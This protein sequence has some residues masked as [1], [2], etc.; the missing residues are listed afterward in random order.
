MY[1]FKETVQK[2]GVSHEEI[3]ENIDIGGPSM[4]RSAL[5]NY[6]F[7]PVLCDPKDYDLVLDE[8]RSW[9][10]RRWKR[11]KSWLPRCSV[12]RLAMMR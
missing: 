7:I 10:R 5:K 11:A 8:I 2:E 6:K 1:P 12:I 4:L 3:I 9:G